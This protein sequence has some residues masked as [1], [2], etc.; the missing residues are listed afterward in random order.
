MAISGRCL[1][2]NVSY[3]GEGN[4]LFQVK[5]YCTDCRKSS[6]AGHAAMMGFPCEAVAIGGETREFHSKADSGTDVVRAFCPNCGT[7]IYSKNAAMPH[8]IF[9]RASTLDD[10]GLFAPQLV[11]WAA[12]A[13]SW[14]PVTQ[15]VPTFAEGPP[16]G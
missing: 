10:P 16:R 9:L 4:P 12:R 5:C 1:C 11:V 8:L 7:G 13:P 14:D 3:S 6:A 15:G 2:G